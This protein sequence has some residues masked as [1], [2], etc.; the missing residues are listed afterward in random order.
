[1]MVLAMVKPNPVFD[2]TPMMMPTHAHAIATATVC[3]APSANASQTSLKLM[4]V[5]FLNAATM[6]VATM[7]IT[8]ENTT[9]V[10]ENNNR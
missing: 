3:V 8:A 7:V 1:M 6:I 10:P 9:V 4:R 5:L 2:V